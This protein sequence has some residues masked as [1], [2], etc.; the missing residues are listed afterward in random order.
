MLNN[1]SDVALG[2][3]PASEY[4]WTLEV[5]PFLSTSYSI[6]R[7]N[8]FQLCQNTDYQKLRDSIIY[9]KEPQRP[10]I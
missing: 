3:M 5:V 8:I 7:N 4:E 6:M 10:E 1:F 2:N 9:V